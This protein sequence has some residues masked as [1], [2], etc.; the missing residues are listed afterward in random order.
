MEQLIYDV[1]VCCV[2]LRA[3]LLALRVFELRWVFSSCFIVLM[4]GEDHANCVSFSSL[5]G[6]TVIVIRIGKRHVL[7]SR[8]SGLMCLSGVLG[9]TGLMLLLLALSMLTEMVN[10]IQIQMGR[11]NSHSASVS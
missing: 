7:C 1:V 11:M 4:E 10:L 6:P 3:A 8:R 9:R 5:T 2:L